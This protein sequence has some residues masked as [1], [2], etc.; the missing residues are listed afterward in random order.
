VGSGGAHH[1]T[2]AERHLMLVLRVALLLVCVCVSGE[3][4]LIYVSAS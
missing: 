1:T 4:F 2:S 3:A